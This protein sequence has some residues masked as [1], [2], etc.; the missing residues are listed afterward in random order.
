MCELTFHRYPSDG[1]NVHLALGKR[2]IISRR[3]QT[4]LYRTRRVGC[5]DASWVEVSAVRAVC[6]TCAKRVCQKVLDI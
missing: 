2:S 6:E 4:G 3:A 5:V 1:V